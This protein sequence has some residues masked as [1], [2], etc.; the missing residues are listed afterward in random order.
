MRRRRVVVVVLVLVGHV[1][2]WI[3]I[4]N[5]VVVATHIVI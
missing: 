3:V 5:A 2:I 1:L 4:S